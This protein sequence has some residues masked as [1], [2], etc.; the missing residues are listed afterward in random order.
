MT[1]QQLYGKKQIKRLL[2]IG[3]LR[4]SDLCYDYVD[5]YEIGKLVKS[6][7][8]P[9]MC[10]FYAARCVRATGE[11]ERWSEYW[12]ER[13]NQLEGE[14]LYDLEC[15]YNIDRLFGLQIDPELQGLVTCSVKRRLINEA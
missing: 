9:S 2:K 10:G 15:W 11:V 3:F 4:E 1:I 8:L 6:N 7:V 12:M 14:T 5:K 13:Y